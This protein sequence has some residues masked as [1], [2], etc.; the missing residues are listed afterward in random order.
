MRYTDRHNTSRLVRVALVVVFVG[1][2]PLRGEDIVTLSSASK[3]DGRVR[4]TGTVLDYT[5]AELSIQ[6]PGG[7]QQKFPGRQVIE[8]QTARTAE[9]RQGDELLA[10]R[11]YAA[12]VQKYND[13]LKPDRETR[14]WVRRLILSRLVVCYARLDRAAIAGDYFLTLAKDDPNT[15][16][17]DT[18][19][20]AW[21]PQSVPADLEQKAREWAGRS[22]SPLAQL[23][24]TSYLLTTSNQANALTLL[25]TL[26]F[27]KDERVAMLAEAQSWRVTFPTATSVTLNAWAERVERFPESLRAGPEFALG[28]ALVQRDQPEAGAIALLR[29][30]IVNSDDRP[31]ASESLWL[32]GQALEKLGKPVD[33]ARLYRELIANYPESSNLSAAQERLRELSA[34]PA[35]TK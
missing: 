1:V 34:A 17:F 7:S 29:V 27:S 31:L 26:A 24:G 22:D 35:A 12:A 25:R 32:A 30:A 14:R 28:R 10:A 11:Q 16:Y 6:L 2:A 8:I 23:L 3:P 18:I 21:R 19:P 15:P 33:A 4:M 13:A 9:H 20:L 5:G